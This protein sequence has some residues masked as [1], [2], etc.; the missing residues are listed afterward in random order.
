MN[1]NTQFKKDRIVSNVIGLIQSKQ[2][3]LLTPMQ[4]IVLYLKTR[5]YLH[6]SLNGLELFGMHG[7]WHTKDY[8]DLLDSLDIFELDETYHAQSKIVLKKYKVNFFNTDSI[9]WLGETENK[10]DMVVSD[11]PAME[12]FYDS[13]GFPTFFSD[14]IKVCNERG[15]IIFNTMITLLPEQ[16]KLQEIIESKCNGRVVKNISYFPRSEKIMYIVLVLE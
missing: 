1:K 8:I 4:M 7:L 5:G 16:E 2:K 3:K 6:K 11:S 10:Y 12:M 13:I 14:L 9:K 15:I